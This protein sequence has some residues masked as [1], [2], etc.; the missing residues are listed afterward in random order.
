VV[1]RL[2]DDEDF[3]RSSRDIVVIDKD[4]K[5]VVDAYG[6]KSGIVVSPFVRS[7]AAAW[8]G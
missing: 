8:H 1:G 5:P 6:P 7:C 4:G 3:S 2:T